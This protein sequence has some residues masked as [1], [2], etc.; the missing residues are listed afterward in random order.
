MFSCFSSL[1]CPELSLDQIADLAERNHM[2]A[3]ELRAVNG[4]VDLVAELEKR[5]GSPAEA[6]AWIE[7][8]PFKVAMLGTSFRLMRDTAGKDHLL[9][10]L[11]WA[12]A[13]GAPYLR[14][15]DGGTDGNEAEIE[16][17]RATLDWWHGERTRHGAV[18]DIAVETHD[19]L[20]TK[21]P[22]ARFIA[23]TDCPVLWDA[24]HTWRKGG[25]TPEET[26]AV[27]GDRVVH[28]HFKDSMR[29]S[30]GFAY[31]LPGEGEFPIQSLLTGLLAK[32]YRGALSLE[33]EKLWHK[34]LPD[35]QPALDAAFSRNWWP[36]AA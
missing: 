32:S 12:A 31:C 16:E 15:F 33:W 10:F 20:V 29:T 27:L 6:A 3:I 35:L 23:E 2:A 8:K 28:V 9:A 30:D 25:M 14:V 21:E 34:Q 18:I 36:S 26:L 17:A 11:D 5:F 24:H 7:G 4:G 1:G 22:L 13:L 19:S